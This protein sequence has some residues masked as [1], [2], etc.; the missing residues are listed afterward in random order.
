MTLCAVVMDNLPLQ[1][2]APLNVGGS[3]SQLRRHWFGFGFAES[4]EGFCIETE[5]LHQVSCSHFHR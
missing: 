2:F 3:I 4:V 1:Q 5:S